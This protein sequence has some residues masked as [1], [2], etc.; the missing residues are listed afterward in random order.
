[1]A[2]GCQSPE[3][4]ERFA[5]VGAEMIANTPAQYGAF[6]QSELVK[7]GAVVK[8]IGFKAE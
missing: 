1:M 7:W 6:V 8:A 5:S 2:P 3:L 4:R